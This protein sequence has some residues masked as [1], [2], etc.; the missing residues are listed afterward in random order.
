MEYT[1]SNPSSYISIIHKDTKLW[2]YHRNKGRRE[3]IGRDRQIEQPK[4]IPIQA[5]GRSGIDAIKDFINAALMYDLKVDDKNTTNIFVQSRH[6]WMGSWQKAMEK[7]KR[8]KESVVLDQ[9][10]SEEIVADARIFLSRSQWYIKRGIPYRRGY[11]LHGPPGTGKTSFCQVLAGE[12][13][14]DLCLLTLTDSELTDMQ[15]AESMRDA[16]TGSIILLEDVD[17]VFVERQ[18]TTGKRQQGVSFSGL[19]NAIDGVASQE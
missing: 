19:L 16:P 5:M 11:L 7:A 12:L 1:W 9:E 8:E 14:A 2:I 6:W 15:L 13:D 18:A 17:A 10:L 3:V 4:E